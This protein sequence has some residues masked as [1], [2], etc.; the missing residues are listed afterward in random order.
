[1]QNLRG[2]ARPNRS[3]AGDAAVR[4]VR[5]ILPPALAAF[6]KVLHVPGGDLKAGKRSPQASWRREFR[7]EFRLPGWRI[8]IVITYQTTGPARAGPDTCR[9]TFS[10]PMGA[11]FVSVP[12]LLRPLV[13]AARADA[14]PS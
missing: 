14:G 13:G 7:L 9:V 1:M 3:A 6:R 2:R 12:H 11:H 10:S 4:V 5:R 8:R